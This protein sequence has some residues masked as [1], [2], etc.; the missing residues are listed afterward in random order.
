MRS[1]QRYIDFVKYIDRARSARSICYFTWSILWI[2]AILKAIFVTFFSVNKISDRYDIDII[3]L[4]RVTFKFYIAFRGVTISHV[5]L[6][7]S[8]YL[9]YFTEC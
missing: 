4:L 2:V 8:Q 9:L 1:I 5:T 6:S 7:C 3:L